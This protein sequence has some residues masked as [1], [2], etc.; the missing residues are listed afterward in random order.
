LWNLSN[1][2]NEMKN[3]FSILL[4]LVFFQLTV[5]SQATETELRLLDESVQ[6]ECEHLLNQLDHFSF[7]LVNKPKRKGYL[8][9]GGGQNQVEN[10]HHR[11]S[12]RAYLS[13][14]RKLK[15][16]ELITTASY[17]DEISFRFWIGNKDLRPK[18]KPIDF[19]LL[20]PEKR[21]RQLFARELLEVVKKDEKWTYFPAGCSACCMHYL[22]ADL[23]S[24]FLSTNPDMIAQFVI[25]SK[26]KKTYKR[27]KKSLTKEL[28]NKSETIKTR[29][30]FRFGR[31][32]KNID[33]SEKL[34]REYEF[35]DE[36]DVVEI[37]LLRR[38]TDN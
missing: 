38:N 28:V 18:I 10:E 26:S 12:I 17:S 36:D 37:W 14:S 4:L 6:P 24:D 22:E 21:K 25:Y 33:N 32:A 15:N 8:V 34:G 13:E 29:S 9:L 35:G 20:I 27:L 1:K 7:E 30:E 11:R 31:N 5:F 3:Y 2:N 16:Y 19:P 23:L